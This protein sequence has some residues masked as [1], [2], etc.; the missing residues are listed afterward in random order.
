[1]GNFSPLSHLIALGLLAWLHL[2]LRRAAGSGEL[3]R[4]RVLITGVLLA[5][6]VAS[7]LIAYR[8]AY[9]ALNRDY[10]LLVMGQAMAPLLLGILALASQ[11]VR[12]LLA[13]F[14]ARIPYTSL[15]R[16]HWFRIAAL[17]TIY[18]WYI[19]ALP[20]HFILPVGVPDLLIGLTALPLG[21][22]IA[23]GLGSERGLFIAWHVLGAS[24][25]LLAIPLIQLS[26]PGPFQVFTQGPNTDGVL[27]FPMSIVPTFVAPLL[28]LLH[29]AALIKVN[30][31][32]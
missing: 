30:R 17:G 32:T 8:G 6:I 11:D 10:L 9:L 7:S 27:S 25:L 4:A 14:I 24:C 19:G 13:R 18:K 3:V 29:L 15:T 22:R 12:A 20:G 16:V 21:Q 23:N 31:E 26:Q 2:T 28:V 1:M 5:W